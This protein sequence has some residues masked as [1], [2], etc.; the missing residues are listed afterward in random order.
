MTPDEAARFATD[1]GDLVWGCF[2]DGGQSARL[3]TA[4]PEGP[5][6]YGNRHYLQWPAILPGPFRRFPTKAAPAQA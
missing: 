1:T 4:S 5:V 2:L 3:V 6:P